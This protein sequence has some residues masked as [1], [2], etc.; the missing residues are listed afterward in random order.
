MAFS[1]SL[2]VRVAY[3]TQQ[4]S[5]LHLF[6]ALNR[7]FGI[8]RDRAEDDL[9]RASREAIWRRYYALIDR[10][11]E[12]VRAR[13]Y[14]RELL[15]EIP[16]MSYARILPRLLRNAPTV[17]FRRSAR[18]FIDLP[19]DIDLS[20][21]PPYYRRNYHWQSDGYL[22]RSSAELYDIG[23]EMLFFGTADVMRRQ[24]IPPITRFLHGRSPIGRLLDIGCGTGRTLL[25]LAV[26]H[27]MLEMIGVDLSPYYVDRARKVLAGA[28]N[29]QLL[30]LNAE[31]LPFRDGFFDVVT[32]VF[33]FHELPRSVRRRVLQEMH[34]VLRPGG[35]V[36]IEDSAQKYD[37]NELAYFMARFANEFHEPYFEDYL[38][39]TLERALEECGF[40]IDAVEPAFVA[41]LVIGKKIERASGL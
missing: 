31:E 23:V 14:P 2:P 13:M 35:L 8:L 12:N 20:C 38:D 22:S 26:A 3:R 4:A 7:R 27:P 36:L 16:I 37:A 29:V 9:D 28:S 39:D 6:V 1:G 18:D 15:F 11:I 24:V 41:K 19:S 34:R 33:T 10:D 30:A 40:A 32:S 25:Q 21:F 17:M 5:L